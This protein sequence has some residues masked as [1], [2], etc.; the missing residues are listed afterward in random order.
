LLNRLLDRS[1]PDEGD[2]LLRKE[3][4]RIA[5]QDRFPPGT[6]T[7]LPPRDVSAEKVGYDIESLNPADGRL[8][9]IEVKEEKLMRAPLL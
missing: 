4:E 2:E 3:I 5:M 7:W 9:F 8:R 6:G 1:S